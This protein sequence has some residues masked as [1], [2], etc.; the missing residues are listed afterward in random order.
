MYT[1]F[2]KT[3]PGLVWDVTKYGNENEEKLWAEKEV[4]F[5]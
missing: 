1:Y 4:T 2:P 3:K 5:C